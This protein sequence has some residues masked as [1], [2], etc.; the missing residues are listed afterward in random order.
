MCSAH[1]C[2][3]KTRGNCAGY[4]SLGGFT[5]HALEEVVAARDND[6]TRDVETEK[7]GQ[8]EGRVRHHGDHERHDGRWR[9]VE[10]PLLLPSV[11]P[12]AKLA[13]LCVPLKECSSHERVHTLSLW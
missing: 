7:H 6:G 5:C 3:F 2:A 8:P 9:R 12:L 11:H 13:Q 1:V 4:P 10:Q